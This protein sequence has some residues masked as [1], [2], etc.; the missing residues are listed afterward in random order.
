MNEGHDSGRL[1]NHLWACSWTWGN[2]WSTGLPLTPNCRISSCRMIFT[3]S[4]PSNKIVPNTF[5]MTKT[6]CAVMIQTLFLVND[7]SIIWQDKVMS[8]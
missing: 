1:L 3:E 2:Q 5:S 7:K 4:T 6:F 8:V